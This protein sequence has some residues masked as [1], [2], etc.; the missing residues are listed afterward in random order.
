MPIRDAALA[1]AVEARLRIGPSADVVPCRDI[2]SNIVV[3]DNLFVN[4][5]GCVWY[6]MNGDRLVFRNNRIVFDGQ[7]PYRL[8]PEAGGTRFDAATR[9]VEHGNVTV[10]FDEGEVA[11]CPP[12][13]GRVQRAPEVRAD[14]RL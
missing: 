6:A 3:E 10:R 2:V 4:P 14:G 9:I 13:L 5:A 1:A 11:S 7:A 8:R 12:T